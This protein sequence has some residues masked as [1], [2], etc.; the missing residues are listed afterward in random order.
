MLFRYFCLRKF[1]TVLRWRNQSGQLTF[2][3]L[4]Q[5]KLFRINIWKLRKRELSCYYLQCQSNIRYFKV[6]LVWQFSYEQY[7][8][9]VWNTTKWKL[10]N[11]LLKKVNY[12][13]LSR[14]K[15]SLCVKHLFTIFFTLSGKS[16][17]AHE[18]KWTWRIL[19]CNLLWQ[20]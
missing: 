19:R 16:S 1:L 6:K 12:M 20:R 2:S 18:K 14:P 7:L 11:V 10:S 15:I 3:A 5:I 13:W 9:G 17:S 8:M 4:S